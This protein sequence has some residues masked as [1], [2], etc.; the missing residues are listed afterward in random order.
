MWTEIQIDKV[1][2][3][4]QKIELNFL[5]G[6]RTDTTRTAAEQCSGDTCLY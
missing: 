1:E 3:E 2:A 5:E 4:A 6:E